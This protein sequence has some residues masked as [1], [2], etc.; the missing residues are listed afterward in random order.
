MPKTNKNKTRARRANGSIRS[1]MTQFAARD[2]ARPLRAA[3]SIDFPN[4]N[5]AA[6]RLCALALAS[7]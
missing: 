7:K 5:F 1:V 6:L 2:M 3:A 4:V